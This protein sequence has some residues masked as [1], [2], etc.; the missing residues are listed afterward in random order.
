MFVVYL[1][2]QQVFTIQKKAIPLW[3]GY[4]MDFQKKIPLTEK[5]LNMFENINLICIN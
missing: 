4:E 3:K 1:F 5:T 2:S